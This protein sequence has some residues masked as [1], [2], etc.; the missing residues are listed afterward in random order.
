M[1]YFSK[2]EVTSVW[3]WKQLPTETL[4]K[5]SAMEKGT[6][7]SMKSSRRPS[8][9]MAHRS[10]PQPESSIK[11]AFQFLTFFATNW[12]S[13]KGFSHLHRV[14]TFA[15]TGHI[16]A[17]TRWPNN[18]IPPSAEDGPA[19]G[20]HPYTVNA[21]LRCST[22]WPLSGSLQR[23]LGNCKGDASPKG[24]NKNW[25][26]LKDDEMNYKMRELDHA[27]GRIT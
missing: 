20:V 9:T 8:I 10:L 1:H 16:N 19:S 11:M 21:S 18:G 5:S 7:R 6:D 24:R 27:I 3:A 26:H 12:M 13:R 22:D 2:K 4:H 17:H 25:S 15:N 14:F 23:T